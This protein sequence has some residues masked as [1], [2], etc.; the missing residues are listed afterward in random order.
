MVREREHD[1]LTNE[2]EK[3]QEAHAVFFPNPSLTSGP[4]SSSQT[5]LLVPLLEAIESIDKRRKGRWGARCL[6]R[7]TNAA[8]TAV[9]FMDHPI[10]IIIIY[11]RLLIEFRTV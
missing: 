1:S 6:Q 11:I 8:F 7:A 3:E 9:A 10:P 2:G 5:R 4:K